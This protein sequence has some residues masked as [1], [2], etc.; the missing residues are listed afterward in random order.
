MFKDFLVGIIEDL[1]S[2]IDAYELQFILTSILL[3]C[4]RYFHCKHLKYLK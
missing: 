1:S 4:L 3:P 2:F